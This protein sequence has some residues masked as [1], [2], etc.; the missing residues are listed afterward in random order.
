MKRNWKPIILTLVFA[1]AAAA[2]L[3]SDMLRLAAPWN[4]LQAMYYALSL[5]FLG[6]VDIGPPAAPVQWV[7]V[8]LWI[9]YFVAPL[10]TF[11]FIFVL[12]QEKLLT[13]LLPWV[14]NHTII[15]GAGRNGI[16]IYQLLKE[17]SKR[18]KVV[19]IEKNKDNAYGDLL[20]KDPATFWIRKSFL[21]I[22]VLQKAR[23]RQARQI[24][25]ST[26]MSL[27]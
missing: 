23:L 15:C 20:E 19:I 9:C 26:N 27:V 8:I 2:F 7:N 14:K 10:L 5:F 17:H 18:G 13:N 22:P 21:D 16:L 12:I 1:V 11:S 24:Y 6:G 25:L 3:Q 4:Y